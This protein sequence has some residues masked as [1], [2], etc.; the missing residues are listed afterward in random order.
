MVK[1]VSLP[2]LEFTPDAEDD[3]WLDNK[4]LGIRSFYSY[5]DKIE[6]AYLDVGPSSYK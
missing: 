4:V 2:T 3:S 6:F 1:K 5:E